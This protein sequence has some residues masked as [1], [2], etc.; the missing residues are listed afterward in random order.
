M[1]EL[2]QL[3]GHWQHSTLLSELDTAYEWHVKPSVLGI[4]NEASDAEYMAAYLQAKRKMMGFEAWK[5]E[6][7]R[8]RLEAKNKH[9]RR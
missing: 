6:Q 2:P 9:G 7:E 1:K 3:P 4:C 8:K 5:Q